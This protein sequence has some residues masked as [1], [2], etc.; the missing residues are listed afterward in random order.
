MRT[1]FFTTEIK[2]MEKPVLTVRDL[3][4]RIQVGNDVWTIVDKIQ[5]DLFRGKTLA[6]VGESGCGKS[7]TALTLMRM[8]SS[9]PV[10]P[11]EGQVIFNGQNLLELSEKEMRKIRGSQIAMI[12]QDPMS[13]LNPV[14]TIGDQLL[15]VAQL[16]LGLYGDA[17]IERVEGALHAVGIPSAAEKMMAYPHQLS[18]GLKQRVMIAMALI[19]EPE[20][21]IADE[22]TTALDVTI[23][24]Q[25]LA[26]I[27]D[28]QQKRGLAV[29][30][31]TH[32]M[33]VVAEMADDVMVMYTAQGIEKGHVQEIFD[34][35][36]HPY[37]LGLFQSLPSL[38]NRK[39]PL[40]PIKGQV[41]QFKHLP[42]GCRFHP[43]CPFVMEKCIKGPV[44]DFEID[45]HASHVAKCRLHDHTEESN[46]KLP[47]L[48][49]ERP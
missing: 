23:Q 9:P 21:L 41:P 30:L 49:A 1:R 39:G 44:P 42:T 5:L 19:C 25:V 16:H 32:D 45:H 7:M 29:L 2:E 18:G 15:E 8:L 35:P 34:Y 13:S 31:I 46:A 43:R 36:A 20:I 33:G 4:T 47:I 26:L 40:K 14:Y 10:L 22:P 48:K 27:K 3:T 11:P 6:L 24:A 12:F 37:T 28:L 38:H 17:A